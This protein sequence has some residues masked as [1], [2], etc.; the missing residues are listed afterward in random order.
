VRVLTLSFRGEQ[1]VAQTDLASLE[2]VLYKHLMNH[3][4]R[5]HARAQLVDRFWG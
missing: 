2:R 1:H 4:E 5:V 3:P